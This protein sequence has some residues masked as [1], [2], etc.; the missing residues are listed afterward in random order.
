MKDKKDRSLYFRIIDLIV[1][2]N[3]LPVPVYAAD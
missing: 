1:S 3:D 2:L